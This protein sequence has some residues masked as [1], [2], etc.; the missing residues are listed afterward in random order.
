MINC[1]VVTFTFTSFKWW[2]SGWAM[3]LALGV[4]LLTD[5][6]QGGVQKL[7]HVAFEAKLGLGLSE[8]EHLDSCLISIRIGK[9]SGE[10]LF[11]CLAQLGVDVL[12]PFLDEVDV[13]ANEY[14]FS[15]L[16]LG[17]DLV[18]VFSFLGL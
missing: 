9:E 3:L 16:E 5:R 17:V 13:G 2:E 11:E 14:C 15:L 4:H 1:C 18:E 10:E 6:L 12:L 7:D 8:L